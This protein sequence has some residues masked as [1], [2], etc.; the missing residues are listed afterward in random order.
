[1][2]V[3]L[4]V[5]AVL[6]VLSCAEAQGECG[7]QLGENAF[8]RQ[9]GALVAA[10][11]RLLLAAAPAGEAG[12]AVAEAAEQLGFVPLCAPSAE[13]VQLSA[14]HQP[15]QAAQAHDEGRAGIEQRAH[16]WHARAGAALRWLRGALE[17]GPRRCAAWA[18]RTLP[19]ELLIGLARGLPGAD[20]ALLCAKR[21]AVPVHRALGWAPAGRQVLHDA[22]RPCWDT[23][24]DEGELPR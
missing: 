1:M 9:K 4:F 14:R 21:L 13:A 24:V 10:L 12:G 23:G 17:Y 18:F 3:T 22:L 19:P 11:F 15:S 2:P 16:G 7:A 5:A 8:D 20:G 6:Q